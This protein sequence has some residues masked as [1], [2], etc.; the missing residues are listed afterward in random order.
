M[1]ELIDNK[2][3]AMMIKKVE[4]F[5][6]TIRCFHTNKDLSR[7]LASLNPNCI[8]MSKSEEL[9]IIADVIISGT[10]ICNAMTFYLT[11]TGN[12]NCY[13][14]QLDKDG[15]ALKTKLQKFKT[16]KI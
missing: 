4:D 5:N 12:N 2:K 13:F 3:N 14:E 7:K 11:G 1:L 8:E 15:L 10:Q 16:I 9:Y 6:G